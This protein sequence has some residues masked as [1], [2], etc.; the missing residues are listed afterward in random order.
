MIRK[1]VGLD[2][3]HG[4]FADFVEDQK[5]DVRKSVSGISALAFVEQREVAEQHPQGQMAHDV[6]MPHRCV[7]AQ[8]VMR[9]F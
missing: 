3:E 9:L 7:V 5:I 4:L 6:E 1:A 8:N 2:G